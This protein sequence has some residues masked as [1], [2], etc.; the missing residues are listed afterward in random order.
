MRYNLSCA[1]DIDQDKISTDQVRDDAP[2]QQHQHSAYN[3]TCDLC[4]SGQTPNQHA[5]APTKKWK[6]KPA[7]VT[8]RTKRKQPFLLRLTVP[9]NEEHSRRYP[10][11]NADQRHDFAD[12]MDDEDIH[13]HAYDTPDFSHFFHLTVALLLCTFMAVVSALD[14]EQHC[15]QQE[16][17]AVMQLV[18]DD[19]TAVQAAAAYD[20]YRKKREYSSSTD[21]NK[22]IPMLEEVVLPTGAATA[23]CALVALIFIYLYNNKSKTAT[24]ITM[25]DPTEISRDG[26]TGTAHVMQ[27]QQPP[28]LLD[29][30]SVV[31]LTVALFF[32]FVIILGLQTYNVMAVMLKPR[33]DDFTEEE[34]VNPYQSL[35][36]VDRYGHV[37]DNA[38]L[39]YLAWLSECLA[40]ALVYQVATACFR[41][42]RAAQRRDSLQKSLQAHQKYDPYAKH[43][44]NPKTT[45]E[46]LRATSWDYETESHRHH[47]SMKNQ[48]RA[49]WYTSLYRLRV[50]TGIW[51]AAC[52]S[53]LIIVASS[54]YIWRQVLWPNI[55]ASTAAHTNTAIDSNAF[56]SYFSI[57]QM[58]AANQSSSTTTTSFSPQLCRRTLSAWFAGLVAAVLCATA[59]A[60]H[61]AA[62]Y[63]N[64]TDIAT[65]AAVAD[66]SRSGSITTT[67]TAA[68]Y[69][70]DVIKLLSTP[71]NLC[72]KTST[73]SVWKTA[74][75]PA[76]LLRRYY[77][78]HH[79]KRLPLRTEL[80]LACLLSILLGVN[81]V[82][83]TGV[84]GPALK[85]G[86]LYYASWLSFLLCVR[87]CLG[88]VEEF[89]NI[90]EEDD[91]EDGHISSA[92]AAE[93]GVVASG[94]KGDD[95][96]H[97]T[98]SAYQAPELNGMLVVPSKGSGIVIS[99]NSSASKDDTQDSVDSFVSMI[100][101]QEKKRLGRVRG[102]FFVSIFCTVCAA[103][104]YDAASNQT[105]KPLSRAQMYMILTPCIVGALSYLLFGLSLSKKLYSTISQFWIGGLLSILSFSLLLGYL[106]LTMHSDDSW[107][108]NSIG[109]IAMANLYYFSWASIVTAGIQMT[110]YLKALFGIQKLD[111]ISAVW[112]AICKV[113]FVILGAALHIWHTI[114]ENCEFD[115]ITLGA[116]TFCSRTVLAIIVSLTGLLVGGFVVL[117]RLFTT[118]C[119]TC[120]CARLQA[121]IEMLISL[122][123]VFLFVAAVALITGI[124]GPGQRYVHSQS[125]MWRAFTDWTHCRYAKVSNNR[126]WRG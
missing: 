18:D 91:D 20:T 52:V 51:S 14:A 50:R 39:Y 69:D 2:Y 37:G 49:A 15:L 84:Q 79:P 68:Y 55:I 58:A 6:T 21:L 8:Q 110:S 29:W 41:V 96:H 35:A 74:A 22:C 94:V 125:T 78:H 4:S 126:R 102:Y 40:I 118:M 36:A 123:L 11:N 90:E 108:V 10:W 101:K 25:S 44:D 104:S 93:N 99:A 113:C 76:A 115:E 63:S 70:R 56:S 114:S 45:N 57:C 61:L 30:G 92:D 9:V 1:L 122:F 120:R 75:S 13:Q 105:S 107:A 19:N 100:E 73:S 119:P 42:V 17:Y 62:R 95:L 85:V 16:I 27:P 43:N 88:C 116:V 83:V 82:L 47:K 48:S 98:K 109:E 38:N 26:R 106:L 117:G 66:F 87:N 124:G 28:P 71:A 72:R 46:L 3:P 31:R 89:Y 77:A 32:L 12:E 24:T 64:R 80:L 81:A 59:I 111:S 65:V 34:D 33:N 67:A 53:C 103:S 112:I 5:Y 97:D 60:M 7:N 121:H 86:N 23:V 54:Q